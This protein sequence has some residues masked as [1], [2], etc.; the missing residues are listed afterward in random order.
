[1]VVWL[2]VGDNH[3]EGPEVSVIFKVRVPTTLFSGP[4]IVFAHLLLSSQCHWNSHPKKVPITCR[5][6]FKPPLYYLT[7]TDLPIPSCVPTQSLIHYAIQTSPDGLNIFV[8]YTFVSSYMFLLPRPPLQ[9]A[10]P[11]LILQGPII[12]IVPSLGSCPH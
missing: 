12:Q 5:K 6:L 3:C 8:F 1:M 11:P 10:K 7:F 4:Q 2:C 9:L